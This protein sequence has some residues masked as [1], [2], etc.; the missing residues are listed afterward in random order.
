MWTD[1]QKTGPGEYPFGIDAPHMSVRLTKRTGDLELKVMA[2]E[3]QGFGA[4]S[5]SLGL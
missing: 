2:H 5:Y 4:G 3:S 1:K